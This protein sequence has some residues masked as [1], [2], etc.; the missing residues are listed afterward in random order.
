MSHRICVIVKDW[1]RESLKIKIK[2]IHSEWQASDQLIFCIKRVIHS[3]Q[4]SQI[5]DWMFIWNLWS[6]DEDRKNMIDGLKEVIKNVTIYVDD[7]C[8]S[9]GGKKPWILVVGNEGCKI[10]GYGENGIEKG[11]YF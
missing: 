11:K 5:E 7:Q 8:R 1:K 9:M 10:N 3:L 4:M 6:T 2:L